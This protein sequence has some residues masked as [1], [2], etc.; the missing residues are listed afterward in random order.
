MKTRERGRG[1]GGEE[2]FK[3]GGAN[4]LFPLSLSLSFNFHQREKNGTRETDWVEWLKV[5]RPR[6]S[7]QQL[8][9]ANTSD[10]GGIYSFGP[11]VLGFKGCRASLP[12]QDP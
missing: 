4:H 1:E 3:E 12:L 2:E 10:G 7:R 6:A 8:A 11:F 5:L 9:Y